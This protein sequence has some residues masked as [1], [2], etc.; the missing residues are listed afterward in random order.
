MKKALKILGVVLAAILILVILAAS[1]FSVIDRVK[2][3]EFYK[4]S[5]KAFAIPGLWDG[6]VQ[7]GFDYSEE[8]GLYVY[9]G[10]MKDHSASRL[11]L[12]DL[13][14]NSRFVELKEKDGTDH[15]GHV[16][17]VSFGGD[18][19]YVTASSK[20]QILMFKTTDVI[21][22]DGVATVCDEFDVFL[23]SAYVYVRENKLYTGEF[24][25]A[26]DYETPEDHRLT[27]P[28]GDENTALMGVYTLGANGKP[29]SADPAYVIS[30][31]G[32]VQGMA[33]DSQGR[34]VLST[35]WGLN[36]SGIY[37]YDLDAAKNGTCTIDGKSYT[38]KYADSD[39]LENTI[40]APP[41]AEEMVYI[42]GKL[43]I[44]NESASMKYIFGKLTSG[45]NALAYNYDEMVGTS[46]NGSS[47]LQ[48][49]Q[50]N[51]KP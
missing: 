32:Q 15:T 47:T 5:E 39:C 10:Y 1:V 14:G 18:Y 25:I 51:K 8:L 6:A 26:N 30:T 33:F 24:Y 43:I 38:V 34:L 29:A 28:A 13:D 9:S 42:D 50:P 17:G 23:S 22:G 41:M 36:P 2:Y 12:I 44:M 7:Q 3:R 4:N 16:G 19:I 21:D 35:S 48:P 11:Y 45:N 31:R 49:V 40:V 20:N 37:V 46:N 27:T